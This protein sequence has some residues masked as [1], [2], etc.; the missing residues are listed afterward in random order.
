MNKSWFYLGATALVARFAIGSLAI[1]ITSCGG[2]GG[3]P[4]T[5]AASP[6]AVASPA[7]AVAPV[8]P[9]PAIATTT[10]IVAASTPP[11]PGKKSGS[12]DVAAG[13]I[14][15]TNGDNWAKTVSKG[16]ADPFATLALQ[17][18][19]V[20]EKNPLAGTGTPIRQSAIANN[21]GSVVKNPLAGTGTPI[22]QSA[23][24]NNPGSVVKTA[25]KTQIIAS[26]SSAIKS[27]VNKPLPAIKVSSILPRPNIT[28][29]LPAIVKNQSKIAAK[30]IKLPTVSAT[31]KIATNG[32]NR[33]LPKIIERL[34]A[35]KPEQAIALEISGVI[36]AGG[37]TQVIVKLPSESFSRYIEVGGRV[38][39]G[40][41]LIKRVEGQDGFS[42]TI[43]LEEVG[44]EVPRKIGD[45]KVAITP[46][47][48]IPAAIAPDLPKPQ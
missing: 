16:R 29:Q 43:I 21:P 2:D 20:T 5:P 7:A 40:K 39:D 10:P 30:P 26:N 3:K 12:V 46:T 38:A 44:I 28:K 37:I 45:R 19:E 34:P 9:A 41:V 22:R 14:A 17:P 24:A 42:P 23:I 13:L 15:P 8:T 1:L 36:E 32:I 18:I 11:V 25:K 48:P 33:A 35:A 4:P 6:S 47:M 27:G 31:G